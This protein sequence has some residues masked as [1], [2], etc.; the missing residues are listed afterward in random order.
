MQL[1]RK[2]TG[3]QPRTDLATNQKDN[4]VTWAGD[5]KKVGY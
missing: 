5:K 2:P 3:V 4:Q 1:E